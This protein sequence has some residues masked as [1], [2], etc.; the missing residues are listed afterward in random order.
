M[1]PFGHATT[2][3]E[4]AH[5]LHCILKFPLIYGV[6]YKK[7]HPID[8]ERD[9]DES[10]RPAVLVSTVHKQVVAVACDICGSTERRSV[11]G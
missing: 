10:F 1:D 2:Y 7:M 6:L 11:V 4:G 5:F 3:E 9:A 8:R